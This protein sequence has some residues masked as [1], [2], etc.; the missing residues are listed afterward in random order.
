MTS[1]APISP[2]VRK[3]GVVSLLT[4]LSSEML[5]AVVPLYVTEV[6]G[7]PISVVGLIEGV[8]EGT[9]RPPWVCTSRSPACSYS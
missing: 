5:Y 8:A 3:L 6:L 1:A 9:A 4:D 7:A 2:N